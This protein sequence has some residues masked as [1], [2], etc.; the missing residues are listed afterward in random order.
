MTFDIYT[1]R[2][3]TQ[4]LTEDEKRQLKEHEGEFEL[5]DWNGRFFQL[6]SPPSWTSCGV[7][8]AVRSAPTKPSINWDHVADEFIAMATDKN[9]FAWLYKEIP[10]DR[11]VYWTSRGGG[12]PANAFSSYTPGTCDWRDSLVIRPGVEQ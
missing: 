8:R 4:L 12:T 7:Y 1:N 10:N 9:Q 6:V 5:G 3:P 2:V 11:E